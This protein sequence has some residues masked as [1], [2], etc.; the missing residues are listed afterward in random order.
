MYNLFLLALHVLSLSRLCTMFFIYDTLNSH[1]TP[2]L[3]MT[4]IN[5]SYILYVVYFFHF[6]VETLTKPL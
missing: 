1:P 4:F 6:T 5:L 2:S 3:T